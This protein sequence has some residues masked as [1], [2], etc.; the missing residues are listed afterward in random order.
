M[1]ENLTRDEWAARIKRLAWVQGVTV[2]QFL[3]GLAAMGTVPAGFTGTIKSEPVTDDRTGEVC[4]QVFEYE[5]GEAVD[6]YVTIIKRG[7][8]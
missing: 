7:N 8:K 3:A 2:D 6:R 4:Q 1:T 5:S